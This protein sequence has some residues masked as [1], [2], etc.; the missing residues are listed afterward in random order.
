MVLRVCFDKENIQFLY[1]YESDTVKDNENA[2]FFDV[3]DESL[4][5]CYVCDLYN[6]VPALF[7]DQV[8]VDERE[9]SIL[10]S[11][12]QEMRDTRNQLLRESDFVMLS[13]SPYDSQKKNQYIQYRKALRDL[14]SNIVDINNFEWPIKP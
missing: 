8:K 11:K 2:Y 9:A 1:F 4:K 10:E 3:P 5:D 7:L 14:P 12:F 13:D 6:G